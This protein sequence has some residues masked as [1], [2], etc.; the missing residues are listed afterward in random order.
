VIAITSCDARNA[1]M[2]ATAMVYLVARQYVLGGLRKLEK[3]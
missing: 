1:A 3:A 2:M